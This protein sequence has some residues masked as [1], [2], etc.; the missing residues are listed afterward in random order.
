MQTVRGSTTTRI[1]AE[2]VVLA[3]MGL[4]AF[5]ASKT[6]LAVILF[7][8]LVA[9][10]HD[11]INRPQGKWAS[12]PLRLIVTPTVT[13]ALGLFLTR[14]LSY[15]VLS[16]AL[17]VA[18]SLMFI[19]LSKSA[20]GPAISAGVLPLVLGERSWYY[21]LAIFADVSL[22]VVI[23]MLWNRYGLCCI[24]PPKKVMKHNEIVEA[25]QAIPLNRFWPVGLMTFV[26]LVGA[27][28]QFTGLRF[29]LFPPVIVMAYEIVGHP[30]APDWVRKPVLFPFVCLLTSTIGLLTYDLV[31]ETVL[32]VMVTVFCSII[33]LRRFEVH[34]PPA[35]AVGLLPFVIKM[36]NYKFPISVFLGTIAL[37][38]Y[39]FGYRRIL[40]TLKETRSPSLVCE[41][42]SP[43]IP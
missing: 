42:N 40:Q 31:R 20:I 9:L 39:C 23:L 21:P 25:H 14:H 22:L 43:S 26:I 41:A 24:D 18:L 12:Q 32:A 15:N 28:A 27:A 11:V 19:R 13:A 33:I 2:A 17:I 29:L 8:E 10:S 37:V 38:L 35:L 6:G 5:A 7:P 4:V 1:V 16:I 3:F 36:P 30:T 34:M